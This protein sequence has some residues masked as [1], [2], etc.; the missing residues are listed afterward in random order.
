MARYSTQL[1]LAAL[2]CFAGAACSDN[3]S[4][5]QPSIQSNNAAD[6]HLQSCTAIEGKVFCPE[7]Q[8]NV[9]EINCTRDLPNGRPTLEFLRRVD[10]AIGHTDFQD[11]DQRQTPENIAAA[12]V[13]QYLENH[14]EV[15][16]DLIGPAAVRCGH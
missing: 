3:Q 4:P 6:Q 7:V 8:G 1:T 16:R 15:N 10:H 12:M 14:P 9:I 5:E 11:A 13:G 2:L